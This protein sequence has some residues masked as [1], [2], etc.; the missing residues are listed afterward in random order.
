MKEYNN[1]KEFFRL[2]GDGKTKIRWTGWTK[3]KYITV[4]PLKDQDKIDV[5]NNVSRDINENLFYIEPY[6]GNNY[7]ERVEELSTR[8]IPL[9][10]A[11]RDRNMLNMITKLN[12]AISN[13]TMVVT[14]LQ[15]RVIKNE[16]R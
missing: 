14:D 16:Q 6:Y 15:R 9:T 2:F 13:L 3:T 1:I 4:K 12:E 5:E 7:W 11:Q 10:A 8:D